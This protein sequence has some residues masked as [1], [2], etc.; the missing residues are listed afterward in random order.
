M[1][2]VQNCWSE[3][4]LNLFC[5]LSVFAFTESG[6]TPEREIYHQYKSPKYSR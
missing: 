5:F 6:L 2:Y 3:D 4:R 1:M